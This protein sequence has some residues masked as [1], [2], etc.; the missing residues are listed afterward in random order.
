MKSNVLNS[1]AALTLI[2]G[3]AT[4]GGIQRDGDRSQ[5]LFEKGENYLEFSATTV[6]P[7]IS[8]SSATLAGSTANITKNFQNFHLGYKRD[9]SDQLTF[10]LLAQ[11][12]VGAD[13]A[14]PAGTAFFAGSTAEIGS[15]AVTGL[16]KYQFNDRFSAY[17]GLRVQSLKGNVSI[18]PALGPAYALSVDNDYQTGYVL[19]AAYE[20]PD[21]ALKI[22]LTYEPEIE[23]EFNDNAGNP[24]NVKIPQAATLHVQSGV[25]QNTIVFGSAR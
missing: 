3:A 15:L 13:V 5:I 21:I 25:A 19:G 23:H 7:N 8:S 17:G 12:L 14:Y 6:S 9:V 18:T 11:E 16:L 10:A 2:A 20:I 1:A 4:A 24:F 22:A